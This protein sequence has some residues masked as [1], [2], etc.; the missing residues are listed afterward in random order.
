MG[1]NISGSA[2]H[3]ED[4]S[5][6]S[7][8]SRQ[9]R[10]LRMA[11]RGRKQFREPPRTSRS[12]S[13]EAALSPRA[14]VAF[15]WTAV[16]LMVLGALIVLP[17]AAQAKQPPP[18][19]PPPVA[20]TPPF[21]PFVE[22]ATSYPAPQLVENT[23]GVTSP[24]LISTL[25]ERTPTYFLLVVN[26]SNYPNEGGPLEVREGHYDGSAAETIRQGG[27]SGLPIVWST[28]SYVPGFLPP[29][30]SDAMV[31]NGTTLT[32][33]A[34]YGNQTVVEWTNDS[35]LNWTFQGLV[36]GTDPSLASSDNLTLLT[37]RSVGGVEATTFPSLSGDAN[38]EFLG[39]LLNSTP[40]FLPNGDAAVVATVA[41][42]LQGSP[43]VEL[44]TSGNA[45]RSFVPS[46]LAP[47]QESAPDPIFNS[48]GSTSLSIPGA[49]AGELTATASPRGVLVLFTAT[50]GGEE[51]VES[52]TSSDGSSSWAGPTIAS[53][54]IGSAR[55]LQLVE[56][57]SGD[58]IGVWRTS[59]GGGASILSQAAFSLSGQEI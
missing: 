8:D 41:D 58:A 47:L 42:G 40:I 4:G 25:V 13:W 17:S 5:K 23:S 9:V 48:I 1:A 49:T 18:P 59:L 35:S 56:T 37:T 55:D 16:V 21:F 31:I 22:P 28:A 39:P 51:H 24:L 32:V 2:A 27:A 52:M 10:S 53:G 11:Q 26:N 44:Y 57:P 29:V 33:A 36:N 19:P 45:G 15:A 34:S 12:R 7:I 54:P 20:P 46:L 6:Q 30:T 14:R 3:V 38:E 43:A 50:F